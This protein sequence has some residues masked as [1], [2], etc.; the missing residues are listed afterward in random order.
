MVQKAIKIRFDLTQ[1]EQKF[2]K[3]WLVWGV[4]VTFNAAYLTIQIQ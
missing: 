1:I 2:I 3:D 4:L